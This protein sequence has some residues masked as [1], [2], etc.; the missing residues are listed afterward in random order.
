MGA[1][2]LIVDDEAVVALCMATLLEDEGYRVVTA[3]DGME[4]AERARRRQPDL[5]ITDLMMPR[6]DGLAMIHELR[7]RGVSI[8][9]ILTTSVPEESLRDHSY[10]SYLQKPY[11]EDDLLRHVRKLLPA[12]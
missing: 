1:R 9:I 11:Y 6:M 10:D 12:H 5:I 7:T 8:P 4:G 3:T 2:I